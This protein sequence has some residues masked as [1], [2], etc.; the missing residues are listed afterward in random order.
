VFTATTH[1]QDYA[2]PH[3]VL[4]PASTTMTSRPHLITATKIR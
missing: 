2:N 1:H 4:P 3:Q